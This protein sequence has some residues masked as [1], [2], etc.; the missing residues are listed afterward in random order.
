MSLTVI[1]LTFY[2]QIEELVITSTVFTRVSLSANKI[3]QKPP[4]R[5]F[6]D[7]MDMIQGPLLIRCRGVYI[8]D[9]IVVTSQNR[10]TI[11][12]LRERTE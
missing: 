12:G 9:S 1:V 7:W 5:N 8:T 2:R 3:T 6:I 11:E 4:I 10:W